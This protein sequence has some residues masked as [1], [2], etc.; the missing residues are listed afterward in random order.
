MK[1]V[2]N[3]VQGITIDKILKTNSLEKIDILKIDIEGAEREVF[4]DSS[5]WIKKIDVLIIELH[6]RLKSGCSRSFYNGSN[7]FDDEWM[8]GE[9]IYMSRKN[10]ITLR[11]PN[12]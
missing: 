3:T 9:N 6:D 2:C 4:M 8:H 7:G 5:S 12:V 11:S 1:N 10:S